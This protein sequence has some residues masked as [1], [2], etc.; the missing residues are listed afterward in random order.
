MARVVVLGAGLS[1]V[2][3]SYEILDQLRDE[4]ELFVVGKGPTYHFVPS[5]PWVAVGWRK[6]AARFYGPTPLLVRCSSFAI[7]KPHRSRS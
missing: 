6:R 5:N 2:L 1:G 7:A 3:A 4:D